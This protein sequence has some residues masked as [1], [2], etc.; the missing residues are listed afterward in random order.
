MDPTNVL[1]VM[2]K[3]IHF[4]CNGPGEVMNDESYVRHQATEEDPDRTCYSK[5]LPLLA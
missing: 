4:I 5:T 1:T 3:Q 2:R